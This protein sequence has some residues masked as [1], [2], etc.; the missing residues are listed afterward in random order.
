MLDVRAFHVFV[1]E[2]AI[3]HGKFWVRLSPQLV[4]MVN[5]MADPFVA[6]FE[7]AGHPRTRLEHT[8]IRPEVMEK[9]VPVRI[10]VY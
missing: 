10:N 1:A 9:V 4:N 7:R 8:E 3:D 6:A 5:D 2:R